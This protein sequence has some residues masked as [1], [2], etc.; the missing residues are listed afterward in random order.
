MW[1]W[2]GGK[3][4]RRGL[5][6][7]VCCLWDERL[8]GKKRHQ[9]RLSTT[10]KKKKNLHNARPAALTCVNPGDG[11][12]FGTEVGPVIGCGGLFISRSFMVLHQGGVILPALLR[13]TD[14]RN[15]T[16]KQRV[17]EKHQDENS[18]NLNPDHY[19][20]KTKNKQT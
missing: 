14:T 10:K 20:K 16:I 1:R 2:R 3:N 12:G 8:G 7:A 13:R 4:K 6:R 11:A 5:S 15:T 17:N 19:L 18:F 9:Q